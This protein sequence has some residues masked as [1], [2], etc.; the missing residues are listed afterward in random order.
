MNQKKLENITIQGT[1]IKL[2]LIAYDDFMIEKK[3]ISDF[4]VKIIND[5]INVEIVFIPKQ[6]RK[7]NPV[8]GGRTLIGREVHYIISKSENKIIKKHYSR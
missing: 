8:L 1:H 4:N 6:A 2:F 7:S 3:T 5:E